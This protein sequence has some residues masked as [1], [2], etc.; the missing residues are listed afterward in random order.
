MSM[1]RQEEYVDVRCPVGSRSLLMRIKADPDS[2]M[3]VSEDNLLCLSCR[4]CTKH[5]RREMERA[6][7]TSTNFRVVHFFNFIGELVETKR[8]PLT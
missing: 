2:V 1:S 3:G 8:E 7:L 4:D 6:G 5:S